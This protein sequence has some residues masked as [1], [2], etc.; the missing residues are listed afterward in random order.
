[1]L[2]ASLDAVSGSV[3]QNAERISP[4]SSG[5]SQASF[6]SSVPQC[7]STSM[8][9]VSGG[10]QLKTSGAIKLCPVASAMGA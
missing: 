6:C 2:V 9:P 7:H 10:L 8:F 5:F 1:M 4:A 3:M